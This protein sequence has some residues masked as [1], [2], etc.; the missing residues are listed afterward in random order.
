MLRLATAYLVVPHDTTDTIEYARRL[1]E[2]LQRDPRVTRAH[3]GPLD[4]DWSPQYTAYPPMD[5][6][7][8]H[9]TVLDA[10]RHMHGQLFSEP[11][12]IELRVPAKNQPKVF[13]YDEI[14][15][16]RYLALWDGQCLLVAWE[17]PAAD[18]VG[19]SGGHVIEEILE[20]A[21]DAIDAG[22]FVQACNPR[23]RYVFLHTA[24][25]A[26]IDRNA[27][28]DWS[29]SHRSG[30]PYNLELVLSAG[31]SLPEVALTAWWRLRGSLRKF[32]TMKNRGRQILELESLV[33][34]DLDHLN[35]LHHERASASQRRFPARLGVLWTHRSWRRVSR[36][37]LARLWLGLGSLERLRR[38]WSDEATSF[39][40]TADEHNL[41]DLFTVDT[42]DE[43]ALVEKLDLHLVEAAVEHAEGRLSSNLL[44]LATVGGGVAGAVV[45]AILTAA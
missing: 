13:E 28:A 33:R 29:M 27:T 3:V 15:S 7:T 40:R 37:Y 12:A 8:S 22:L 19:S 41:Q 43:V 11:V 34:S 32:A 42:Y 16:E 2:V 20:E 36:F 23:C 24:I 44:A 30:D 9:S 26:T 4:R 35:R 17:Q 21:V 6:D 25:R 31:D 5:E 14:P 45:A 38:Q 10:T 1:V 39:R 18:G